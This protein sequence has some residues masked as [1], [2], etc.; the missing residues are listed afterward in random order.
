MQPENILL[1]IRMNDTSDGVPGR[2]CY[3]PVRLSKEGYFVM[4]SELSRSRQG[5]LTNGGKT[6]WGDSAMATNHPIMGLALLL[7]QS[8]S[9]EYLTEADDCYLIKGEFGDKKP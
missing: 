8:V 6:D 1:A 9:T 4:T 5:A 3:A 7:V 2:V